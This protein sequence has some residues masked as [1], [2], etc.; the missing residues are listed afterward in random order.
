[1]K[2]GKKGSSCSIRPGRGLKTLDEIKR[3]AKTR[4]QEAY[5]TTREVSRLLGGVI[6]RSTV[7]RMF[8]QGDFE[9]RFNP[10]TGRRE[11]KWRAVLEWLKGKGF[12]VDTIG[13]VEKRQGDIR[14]NL[15]NK[16]ESQKIHMPKL[17]REK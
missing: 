2:I 5:F 6:S 13:I 3:E 17:T 10:L 9:G 7:A 1:M 15:H 16:E 14:T 8:D 11:I 4:P 12:T